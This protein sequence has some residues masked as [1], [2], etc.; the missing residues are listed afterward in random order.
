MKKI[1][2]YFCIFLISCKTTNELII[3]YNTN[4]NFTSIEYD[5]YDNILLGIANDQLA[6]ND[7]YKKFE[8]RYVSRKDFISTIFKYVETEKLNG[9][10]MYYF[11]SF[12]PNDGNYSDLLADIDEYIKNDHIDNSFFISIN[13]MIYVVNEYT[14]FSFLDK[15]KSINENNYIEK[16]NL[17][18]SFGKEYESV[19]MNFL[20]NNQKA[21]SLN[22]Y[23][24]SN[25]RI[26]SESEY[27]IQEILSESD[28]EQFEYLKLGKYYFGIFYLSRIGFN[29]NNNICIVQIQYNK[30]ITNYLLFKE[31]ENWII[32][33]TFVRRK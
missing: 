6:M 21:Y 25:R 7:P 2:L 4:L 24:L 1:I 8:N 9:N 14:S 17:L 33:K 31:N 32:N 3:D 5:I 30:T 10:E 27:N 13:Q 15:N 20:Q 28:S 29:E 19:I 22:E 18:H 23:I 26:I 12:V 16:N 11:L